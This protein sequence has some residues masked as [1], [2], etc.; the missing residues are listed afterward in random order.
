[1][2]TTKLTSKDWRENDFPLKEAREIVKDLLR[3]NPFIYW[4]DF[5]FHISLGW[6][7]FFITLKTTAFFPTKYFFFFL[8]SLALYRAAIFI[9]ELAHLKKGTFKIFGFAWNVLCGIP[10]MLPSFLYYGVHNDHH[11]QSLYGTKDDGEYF[12]FAREKP[13][14]IVLYILLSF[15][16][17]VIFSARFIILAP[18][19]YF[20]KKL[21]SIVLERASSLAIDLRYRRPQSSLGVAGTWKAQECLTSFY[22]ITIIVLVVIGKLP[23]TVLILWYFMVTF[24]FLLNSLRTLAAHCYRSPGDEV[25]EFSEQYFD[26]VNVPGNIFTSLWAP[27]GLRFHATHHLFP[28]IPY[29]ALGQTHKRLMEFLGKNSHYKETIRSGLLPALGQLWREA[30]N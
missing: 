29:H 14:K 20:H 30:K 11:K 17:P 7:A 15:L 28:R 24:I 19:S 6:G 21:R 9:H 12:P 16:L 13:Y 8:S 18:L 25:M 23:V 4:L 26:S 22:G 2:G 1:M 5:L 10:L 27:V 3:P